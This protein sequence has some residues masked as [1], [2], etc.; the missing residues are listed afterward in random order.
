MS[1]EQDSII[2]LAKNYMALAE[3]VQ[4][5][6]SEKEAG[7]WA[8]LSEALIKFADSVTALTKISRQISFSVMESTMDG[9]NEDRKDNAGYDYA[10]AARLV[11]SA[12]MK[13][14]GAATLGIKEAE[15]NVS[16]CVGRMR[17]KQGL[18]LATGKPSKAANKKDLN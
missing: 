5:S 15:L 10:L 11:M 1:S 16:E 9:I 17:I 12:A 3:A 18:E 6:L 14:N 13:L 8:E 7:R 4:G 2:D